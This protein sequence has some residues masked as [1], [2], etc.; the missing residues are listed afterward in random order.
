MNTEIWTSKEARRRDQQAQAIGVPFLSLME[1]AGFQAFR[2]VRRDFPRKETSIGVLVGKGAN[3][4]DGLVAARHLAT[5]Y[6]VSVYLVGEPPTFPGSP[7]LLRAAQES[8]V[9]LESNIDCDV[10]IDGV[11]GT[12][13]HK[14]VADEPLNDLLDRVYQR[15]TPVIALDMVSRLDADT[16][17]YPHRL[18]AAVTTIAFGA[19]KWGHWGYPGMA[20]RGHL[21]LADIGLYGPSTVRDGWVNAD[22]AKNW[23]P[24]LDLLAHKY[25]RGRVVVIGGSRDMP[26]APVLAGTAALR[27]GAGLV[28]LI[29]PEGLGGR[30][31]APSPLLVHEAP[32]SHGS[33]R[34]S[35]EETVLCQ[36]ADVILIGPGLGAD[37]P[38]DIFR[39]LSGLGHPLVVDADGF[40]L[41]R[42]GLPEGSM[43]PLI[44]TP[45]SGEAGALLDVSAREI[46]ENRPRAVRALM[47]KYP[48]ATVILKGASSI[49][50]HHGH[51]QVN[52]TG[53]PEMAT[54]GSGDVLAGMVAGLLGQGLTPAT[55]AQLAT[56]W[57]G[58]AGDIA[59]ADFGPALIATDL[60][61]TLPQAWRQIDERAWPRSAP[62]I[63]A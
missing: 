59:A 7:G 11:F 63:M 44:L 42:A 37:V 18:G 5:R 58:W 51:L 40:R 14:G 8:G 54:P 50:G 45:H 47:A 62:E 23:L 22:Q 39:L 60:I 35:H 48:Q 21:V 56:Y 29:I 55:A 15:D 26:G 12:G 33:L 9:R 10:I 57:H 52:T 46:D 53:T 20:A 41:L 3:G 31:R 4:G 38:T 17:A 24:R 43:V 1:L 28:T 49:T 25:K 27:A 2:L 34:W 16:G 6:R 19:T 61:D 13:Y 30:V 36:K 32:A